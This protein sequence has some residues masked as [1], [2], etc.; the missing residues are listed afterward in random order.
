ML[1]DHAQIERAHLGRLETGRR[2]ICLRILERIAIA[3][4]IETAELLK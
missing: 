1:A 2:E 4:G 3:L